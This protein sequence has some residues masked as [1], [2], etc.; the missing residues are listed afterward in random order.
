M[1]IESKPIV[2]TRQLKFRKSSVHE[3]TV[4]SN[5]VRPRPPRRPRRSKQ[6][7]LDTSP[8]VA[9]ARLTDPD[10]DKK[11]PQ[12]RISHVHHFKSLKSDFPVLDQTM[13]YEVNK[14]SLGMTLRRFQQWLYQNKV[15][16][17]AE[18]T[19]FTSKQNLEL[20][21]KFD[22]AMREN[23]GAMRERIRKF[24]VHQTKPNTPN[25]HPK[26]ISAVSNPKQG[27]SKKNDLDIKETA[28]TTSWPASK[29]IQIKSI[30]AP[31]IHSFSKII[32]EGTNCILLWPMWPIKYNASTCSIVFQNKTFLWRKSFLSW[33]MARWALNRQ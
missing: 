26:K 19:R 20:I 2:K 30:E 33:K 9:P 29:A 10:L 15:L 13:C 32:R 3:P 22:K 28:R 27:S 11:S 23:R 4:V 8:F 7:P 31:L 6:Q 18:R 1:A 12:F 25:S 17:Q 24:E 5:P 21:Q 14:S 16:C